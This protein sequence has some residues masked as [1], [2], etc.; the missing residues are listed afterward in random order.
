MNQK[1]ENKRKK[2]LNEAKASLQVEGFTFNK[3][4]DELIL[5]ALKGEITHAEF[6]KAAKERAEHV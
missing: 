6:L 4:D 5:K 2:A 1:D 3:E